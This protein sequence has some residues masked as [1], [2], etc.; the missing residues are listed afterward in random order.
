[1][2]LLGGDSFRGGASSAVGNRLLFKDSGVIDDILVGLRFSLPWTGVRFLLEG[3]VLSNPSNGTL[4]MEISGETLLQHGCKSEEG[5]TS[6]K[7]ILFEDFPGHNYVFIL[8]SDGEGWTWLGELTFLQTEAFEMRG[9]D[10]L[11]KSCQSSLYASHLRHA[12]SGHA[13]QVIC[14]CFTWWNCTS[15]PA[16]THQA[17]AYTLNQPTKIHTLLSGLG[18]EFTPVLLPSSRLLARFVAQSCACGSASTFGTASCVENAWAPS[19]RRPWPWHPLPLAG[20]P[21]SCPPHAPLLPPK[22][23][24]KLTCSDLA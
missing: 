4:T 23:P 10:S 16:P 12:A 7:M 24:A 20:T 22:P 17:F 21:S 19:W 3:G 13:L 1:M 18:W 11:T 9:P 2:P 5:W 6:C 14:S 8:R 15:R